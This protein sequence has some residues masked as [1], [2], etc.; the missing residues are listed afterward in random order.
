MKKKFFKMVALL[1][2]LVLCF[3]LTAC[4]G[5]TQTNP[6][7]EQNA[8]SVTSAA[9]TA[10]T[11][12][13]AENDKDASKAKFKICIFT[14]KATG[15]IVESVE[16]FLDSIDDDL[17]FSY[18][19]RFAADDAATMLSNIESAIAEGFNGII[20]MTDKGNNA[21]I[22]ELCQE[23]KVYFGGT[24][25]NQ[26][27]SLNSSDTGY[28]TLKHPYYVGSIADGY[29]DYKFET[30]AYAKQIADAYNA[31]ADGE[32]AGSIGITTNPSKWTPGQQIAAENMYKALT[33]QYS[34]PDSAF[35]TATIN[36]RTAEETYT[37]I[38][39]A[40]GTWQFP[41]VDVSSRQLPNA[42]FQSNGKLKLICSYASITFIEPALQTAGLHGKV[43]VWTCGYEA[44]DYLV[45]NFGT[46]G[47]KT[48]QGFR[49]APIEDVAFP[50]VQILDKLNGKSYA[51]KEAKVKELVDGMKTNM[52]MK[53]A[54]KDYM[55]PESSSIIVTNNT[56][57]TAFI[58]KYV[59]GNGKGESSMV[60]AEDLKKL[61]VTYNADATYQNL[62]TYFDGEG[63]LTVDAIK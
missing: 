26:A 53:F 21:A 52:G 38:K 5:T 60:K 50:L 62:M 61:M 10:D 9:T 25:S 32:K 15:S 30:D 20:S 58:S 59:Y 34:I 11:T 36:K 55:I 12:Q 23:S 33:T 43:K 63:N 47:D 56:Q 17:A 1:L 40:A 45:K 27:S 54:L 42:Y 4:G 2:S 51:D 44:E 7:T 49:T 57:F 13:K 19:V 37:G 35:A 48:Y 28:D 24:W 14:L 18:E 6:G 31:L 39:L 46:E 16:A 41:Q 22:L 3:S 29:D 8:S